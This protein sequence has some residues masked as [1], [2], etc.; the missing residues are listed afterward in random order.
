MRSDVYRKI[1]DELNVKSS[2]PH[3]V[4]YQT[5]KRYLEKK[6]EYSKFKILPPIENNENNTKSSDDEQDDGGNQFTLFD[7]NFKIDQNDLSYDLNIKN[8]GLFSNEFE[9][10]MQNEWSDTLNEIVWQF[11]RCPCAWRFDKIQNVANEKIVF[12][13]CRSMECMASL[14]AYTECDQSKLKIVIKNFNPDAV[15]CEKRAL[16]NKNKAKV[17]EMSKMNKA[18]YVH[19]EL[20]NEIL[21]SDDYCAAHL[22]N[23]STLRKL[24]QRENEKSYRDPDPV[25]SL[26]KLKEDSMFH[27]SITDIGLDPF[28]CYFAT[29]KQLE[30][31]RLSTRYKRIIISIDSTGMVFVLFQYQRVCKKNIIF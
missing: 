6:T 15:L 20:S 29:P 16:K 4:V 11:S 7:P 19:A 22:P 31:L 17:S 9:M 13:T 25:I 14:Y 24:K 18:S 23:A 3:K 1:A 28:Y 21:R 5:Y 27:K 30:W 12:G 10:K 26:R 2:E 8:I